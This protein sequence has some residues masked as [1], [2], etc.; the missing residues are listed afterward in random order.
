MVHIGQ[1]IHQELLRQERTPAWLARKINCQRP[2]I[3][4]I[5]SQPSINTE[6][7]ERISRALG[8]DFFMVLSE[9]IKKEM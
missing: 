9:C 8:V 1:L 7:L 6:L 2:N 3:Y 4:Y 5:F